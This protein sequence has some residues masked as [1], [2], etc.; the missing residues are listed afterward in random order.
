VV[1]KP[2]S[3]IFF[4]NH[5]FS[6][7]QT[8]LKPDLSSED[9]SNN[10][11]FAPTAHTTTVAAP[12]LPVR[13]LSPANCTVMPFAQDNVS[14]PN[15]IPKPVGTSIVP[16]KKSVHAQIEAGAG[17]P[18]ASKL[19]GR[20]AEP[21][22]ATNFPLGIQYVQTKDRK[23]KD[24]EDCRNSG[25][26]MMPP[27]QVSKRVLQHKKVQ[28]PSEDTVF[29]APKTIE[30]I[31]AQK[32]MKAVAK[33]VKGKLSAVS[34]AAPVAKVIDK[35]PVSGRTLKEKSEASGGE[36]KS[37]VNTAE[38]PLEPQPAENGDT[39]D[40]E[41]DVDAIDDDDFEA[42]MRALEDAL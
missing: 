4:L 6:G 13:A 16:I 35:L 33:P 5:I 23:R 28:L 9:A 42:Q 3:I 26:V 27:N 40:F 41:I 20:A 14:L 19:L 12:V 39:E 24:I 2:A 22:P 38:A 7:T 37:A 11:S 36:I 21:P 30:E 32:K 31:R 25:A 15:C 10:P 8:K 17:Q 29:N 1:I 18:Q 34:S